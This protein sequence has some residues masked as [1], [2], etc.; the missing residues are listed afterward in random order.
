MNSRQVFIDQKL[1]ELEASAEADLSMVDAHWL[2][3][4][5]TLTSS[6]KGSNRVR[7]YKWWILP[8]AGGILAIALI[9]YSQQ[10][11]VYHIFR[12]S[13]AVTKQPI[14]SSLVDTQLINTQ[15]DTLPI[16]RT[17]RATRQD[18]SATTAKKS[19]AVKKQPTVIVTAVAEV[20][21]PARITI[22][23]QPAAPAKKD[24]ISIRH[25][26]PVK[27]SK[28]V[29]LDI[30][31]TNRKDTVLPATVVVKAVDNEN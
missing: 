27:K 25:S 24:T 19:K 12:S 16:Q 26:N 8:A 31:P 9:Y 11:Q 29:I 20:P 21:R 5:A 23:S 1:R 22:R 13:E 15:Q 17:A 4:R 3:M 14:E 30:R 2:Q 28:Q 6:V 18:S 7:N 10:K